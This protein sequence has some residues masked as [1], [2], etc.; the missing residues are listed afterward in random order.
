MGAL[1]FLIGYI[2]AQT[3]LRTILIDFGP[4]TQSTLSQLTTSP[5][6]NSNYWNNFTNNTAASASMAL[7]DK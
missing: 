6:A 3:L 7:V 2:N 5:D 4:A 1:I